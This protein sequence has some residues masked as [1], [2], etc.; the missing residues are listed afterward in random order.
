MDPV[1]DECAYDWQKIN[2]DDCQHLDFI[3]KAK[4]GLTFW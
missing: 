2:F 4:F 3:R 1:L